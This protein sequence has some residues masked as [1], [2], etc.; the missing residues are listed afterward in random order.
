MNLHFHNPALCAIA[1]LSSMA[2]AQPAPTDQLFDSKL[3]TGSWEG[4]DGSGTT[5]VFQFQPGG[6]VQ[7]THNGERIVPTVP[8]GPTLKYEIN[9]SK[10]PMWLD[11]IARDPSGKELGRIKMIFKIL[12]PR[13]M[14]IRVSEDFSIRPV[15]F[16]D[17]DLSK[18][19]TLKKI[20]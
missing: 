12:G 5:A 2:S 15:D 18:T 19:A 8:N 4:T 10:T 6:H 9:Q 7:L 20:Y 17:T 11:L 1:L 3:L 16:D 13:E 14:K